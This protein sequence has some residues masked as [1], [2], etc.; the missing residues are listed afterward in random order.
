MAKLQKQNSEPFKNTRYF[1]VRRDGNLSQAPVWGE[2]DF[3]TS[4]LCIV[5]L[6]SFMIDHRMCLAWTIGKQA[7]VTKI[8]V[9]ENTVAGQPNS[10]IEGDNMTTLQA[11]ELTRL[12]PPLGNRLCP[13]AKLV[14][15]VG[16]AFVKC[17]RVNN[18]IS[19]ECQFY[20][21]PNA[22]KTIRNLEVVSPEER[23]INC[24]LKFSPMALWPGVFVHSKSTCSFRKQC[25]STTDRGDSIFTRA[26]KATGMLEGLLLKK[27][28][29]SHAKAAVSFPLKT[30]TAIFA[31]RG[32]VFVFTQTHFT[33]SPEVIC[34]I[35]QSN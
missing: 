33:Y 2:S 30:A 5:L 12:F 35:P 24:I 31:G 3:F 17:E 15:H 26:A 14:F 11:W 1:S 6:F 20:G 19:P 16:I 34:R 13:T 28:W 32:S 4:L 9:A 23:I 10:S 27:W 18:S 25:L 29:S 22:L 7:T 21:A 8:A